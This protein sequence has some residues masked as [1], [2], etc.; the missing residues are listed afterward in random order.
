MSSGMPSVSHGHAVCDSGSEVFCQ[1]CISVMLKTDP[2][3]VHP[4][5]NFSETSRP[6][7]QI[8]LATRLKSHHEPKI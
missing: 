4:A 1:E 8:G 7:L 2:P 3:I 6:F 5:R